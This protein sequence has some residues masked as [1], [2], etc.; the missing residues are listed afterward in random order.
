MRR[1]FSDIAMAAAIRHKLTPVPEF[2]TLPCHFHTREGLRI[3]SL[4]TLD[5]LANQT[6]DDGECQLE[7]RS[8]PE[9]LRGS[10][11]PNTLARPLSSI[12]SP[13]RSPCISPFP[14]FTLRLDINNFLSHAEFKAFVDQASRRLPK[15]PK[16][17]A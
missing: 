9:N 12:T 2:G 10:R 7:T 15:R 6:D 3:Q 16:V 1:I 8:I 17:T 13:R 11:R 5:R 4:E 14:P